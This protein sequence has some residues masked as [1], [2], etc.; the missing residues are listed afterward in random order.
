MEIRLY[1]KNTVTAVNQF[2]S[3]LTWSGDKAQASRQLAFD[4]LTDVPG[5]PMDV[6]NGDH[7]ELL[8]DAG[9]CKF[10]GMV[11][12]VRQ[13][14]GSPAAAVTAYDRGI[15]LAN[16]DGTCKFRG[17]DPADAAAQVCREYDIP[18][19]RLERA[20]VAVSRIFAGVSLWQIINTMYTKA[21]EQTGKRYMARFVG[22]ELEVVERTVR[23]TS[24]VIRPG[25]NL[26][27]ASTTRSVVN[28]RNSVAIYDADG[29]RLRVLEDADA[30]ALYG[31]MQR[32]ITQRDG[33]DATAEAQG[34]LDDNGEA[35][36]ISVTAMG[37]M[38][39]ITGNTVVVHQPDTGLQ[40]VF[41]VDSDTHQW[42]KGL[43][44]MRL[45]LNLKNMA[46]TANAGSDET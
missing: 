31:L 25:S 43:H 41:W 30:V 4:L 36:T 28:L 10:F 39:V 34:I 1:Q 44:T 7:V 40:G 8:D 2:V 24:L 12:Q 33:E 26:L 37:D 42:T 6:R 27:A 32:H 22:R 45:T 21:G 5:R 11:V 14:A 3:G 19:G 29:N 38:D 46:Y 18:Y 15:Y 13:T 20:G 17:I 35:Q 9:N 23:P 16:N